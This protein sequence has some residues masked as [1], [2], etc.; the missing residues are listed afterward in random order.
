VKYQIL[1]R[2]EFDGLWKLWNQTKSREIENRLVESHLGFVKK[3]VSKLCSG[4]P[5]DFRKDAFQEGSRALLRALKKYDLKKG[6]KFTSYAA[7]WINQAILR[8]KANN[9]GLIRTPVYIGNEIISL[10]K[11]EDNLRKV[12]HRSPMDEELAKE[13]KLKNPAK[14]DFLRKVYKQ[15]LWLSFDYDPG[16]DGVDLIDHASLGQK[17]ILNRNIF[18]EHLMQRLH[19]VTW[20]FSPKWRL[21]LYH[22]Y[23]LPALGE[24]KPTMSEIGKKCGIG[25]ERV[26]QILVKIKNKIH[27][28]WRYLDKIYPDSFDE[29][30]RVSG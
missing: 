13:L 20:D 16:V 22:F 2:E 19:E 27:T 9:R 14:L 10:L 1:S 24:K 15:E 28:R 18:P 11:K 21:V 23:L 8:L 7:W 29:K 30:Y 25:R 4:D 12:L 6:V 26:R 17:M 5:E 3:R